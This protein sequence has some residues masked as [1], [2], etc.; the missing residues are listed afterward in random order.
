[1]ADINYIFKSKYKSYIS[2]LKETSFDDKNK[3]YLCNDENA[4][5]YNFDNIVK[6][7]YPSK[8]PASYD[9]I[10][11]HHNK[12]FCIEFKNQTYSDIDRNQLRLKLQNGKEVLENI[13]KQN[14][15]N[16]KDYKFIFCVAYKDDG[17]KRWRRGIEK[18]IIQFELESYVPEYYNDIKTNDI[19]FLQKSI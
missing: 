9:A 17:G 3:V 1:M 12:V 7:M 8:Q 11:L 14:N 10:L 16:K 5:V 6:D 13:L 18:N 19:T 4:L 2:T 15:I